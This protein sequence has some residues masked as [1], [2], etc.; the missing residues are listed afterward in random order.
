MDVFEML[1][2]DHRRAERLFERLGAATEDDER[3]RLF[4]ELKGELD[5]HTSLEEEIFYPALR[6]NGADPLLDDSLAEHAGIKRLISRMEELDPGSDAWR[7]DLDELSRAVAHHVHEEENRLFPQARQALSKRLQESLAERLEAR[8]VQL[9]AGEA[10][11]PT[12]ERARQPAGEVREWAAENAA[13]LARQA[14]ERGRRFVEQQ[15]HSAADGARDV[16]DALRGTGE[17]LSRRGRPELAEYLNQ[18]ADGL[19]RLSDR[20]ARG[21][22]DAMLQEASETAR[23]HPAALFGGAIAAGFLV[24]RFLKSSEQRVPGHG[25]GTAQPGERH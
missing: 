19:S 1:A 8:R 10:A 18:A 24:S 25:T 3:R 6:H 12:G 11:T 5:M 22:V 23:R 20:L 21:D 13:E 16:A 17:D 14:R 15:S 2:M 4:T 7:A 9:H